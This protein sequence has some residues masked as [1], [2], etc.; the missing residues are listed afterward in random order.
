MFACGGGGDADVESGTGAQTVATPQ[1]T[2]PNTLCLPAEH[3]EFA[4]NTTNKK[5]IS[6]C[7]ANGAVQYRF[8]TFGQTPDMVVPKDFTPTAK[9]GV[10]EDGIISLAGGGAGGGWASFKNGA[11]TYAVYD[12]NESKGLDFEG[13]SL[14]LDNLS[15]VMVVQN[16]KFA[17]AIACADDKPQGG[18]P[19]DVIPD[20]DAAPTDITAHI[21]GPAIPPA[22]AYGMH[23]NEHGGT[24][25]IES[26]DANGVTF[27]LSVGNNFG[28]FNQGELPSSKALPEGRS[29][30]FSDQE[31]DCHLELKPNGTSIAVDQ[32]G[33]CG[34]GLNVSA[35]DTY[36]KK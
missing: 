34:F 30:V 29:W 13:Q 8:G 23:T 3:V 6:I 14:G 26:A 32:R 17:A 1:K 24:L 12:I 19:A 28:G 36:T 5:T 4:C 7:S 35:T 15:G 33:A 21:P 2:Q 25:T 18:L 27:S 22:G 31:M 16:G 9:N 10:A 11:T 20:G